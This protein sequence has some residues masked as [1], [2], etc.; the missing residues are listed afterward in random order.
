MVLNWSTEE[1]CFQRS[2]STGR[3]VPCRLAHC[4]GHLW[5]ELRFTGLEREFYTKAA[6][7]H[8]LSKILGMPLPG[9]QH[10][11]HGRVRRPA[12]PSSHLAK[13]AEPPCPIEGPVL[14]AV[15][16]FAAAVCSR[17]VKSGWKSRLGAV[18]PFGETNRMHR[19]CRPAVHKPELS[20]A[21]IVSDPKSMSD[22][23]SCS[24]R[25]LRNRTSEDARRGAEDRDRER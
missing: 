25:D 24:W 17:R 16:T 4:F 13:H 10:E 5:R 15:V 18:A 23:A 1:A 11:R 9:V 6:Q 14:H 3:V 20:N 19:T 8:N 22:I 2:E 21:G 7:C 12:R